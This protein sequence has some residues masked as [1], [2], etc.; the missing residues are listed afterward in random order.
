VGRSD[1]VVAGR[2]REVE[3]GLQTFFSL[4]LHFTLRQMTSIPLTT[5]TTTQQWIL[6]KYSRSR[7]LP[8]PTVKR[9]KLTEIKDKNVSKQPPKQEFDHL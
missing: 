9:Q 1:I 4:T 7:S 6:T 3:M 2:R 5:T 8:E